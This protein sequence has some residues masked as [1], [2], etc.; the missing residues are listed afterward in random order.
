MN[1]WIAVSVTPDSFAHCFIPKRSVPGD[2]P[3]LYLHLTK[4]L[5]LESYSLFLFPLTTPFYPS[6]NTALPSSC[7][8]T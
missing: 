8:P 5:I 3:R 1:S 4:L 6:W 7:K 2:V